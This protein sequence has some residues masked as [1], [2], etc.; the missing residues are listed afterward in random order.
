MVFFLRLFL[1]L[2]K[3]RAA[4]LVI[5]VALVFTAVTGNAVCFYVFDRSLRPGLTAGDAL[6]YSVVSITTIGYGDLSAQSGGAR[7]GTFF[8]IIVL[9]LTSF[10]LLLGIFAETLTELIQKGQRGMADILFED[11]VLIVNYPGAARVRHLIREITSDP[12]S[13][14][15]EIVLVTDSVESLPFSQK[16][17]SFV[18]GSPLEEETYRR[19][20]LRRARIA[21]VLSPSYED[22]SS[23]AVVASIVSFIESVEPG[24]HTVAE[25]LDERHRILFQGS[26]VN[27]IVCG[28]QIS[29]NLLTQ[30]MRDPGVAR[31]LEVIT[32]NAVEPTLFST[33]VDD[34]TAVRYTDLAKT[35]LDRGANVLSVVRGGETFTTFGDLTSAPGD[36]IVYVA[37]RRLGWGDLKKLA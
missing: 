21:L 10:T 3:S 25:C 9:G 11:H 28:L 33:P 23:D 19:A 17:V 37:G 24:I 29:T 4:G 27:S 30:E 34:E 13:R 18:H 12:Q 14:G 5:V 1:T 26:G 31:T 2:R 36:R 15:E 7:L 16:K 20:N 8:F 22:P 32:S 35:L 6:W